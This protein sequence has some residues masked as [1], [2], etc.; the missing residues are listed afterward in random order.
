[1]LVLVALVGWVVYVTVLGDSED[2]AKRDKL[3]SEAQD[4]GQSIIA[5]FQH[6]SEK[7]KEGTYDE[8]LANLDKA[9][10]KLREA[11]EKGDFQQRLKE[12][13][14]EKERIEE[15]IEQNKG[16]RMAEDPNTKNNEDLKKLAENVIKLKED[17]DKK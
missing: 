3:L 13:Q 17:M 16:A 5:V 9:I 11:D 10:D 1:M 8:L 7:V 12:L 2:K 14:A 4:F 6:E 15:L